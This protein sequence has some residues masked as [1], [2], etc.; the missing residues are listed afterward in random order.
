MINTRLFE[1]KEYPLTLYNGQALINKAFRFFTVVDCPGIP[2]EEFD[3]DFP[4]FVSAYFRVYN[5]RDG[6]LIKEYVMTQYGT[7]LIVNANVSDMTFDSLGD[8]YYQIGYSDG[9][10][11]ALRYG[12][13]HVI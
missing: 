11:K 1:G 2:Y 6:R 4:G 10:E 7:Y 5:E 3:F 8:Y 13:L 9:Y 12:K